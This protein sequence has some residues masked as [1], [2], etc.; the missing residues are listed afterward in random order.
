MPWTARLPLTLLSLTMA[1]NWQARRR[2]QAEVGL[3]VARTRE[4]QPCLLAPRD[5]VPLVSD[6]CEVVQR[7]CL[8]VRLETAREQGLGIAGLARVRGQG[9]G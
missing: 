3:Q 5:G 4:A 9:D 6:L 7:P 8:E 2:G 1:V